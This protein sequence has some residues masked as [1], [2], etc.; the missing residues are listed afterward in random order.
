MLVA[1]GWT[2][3]GLPGDGSKKGTEPQ[4]GSMCV[5][6]GARTWN[7]HGVLWFFFFPPPGG[8]FGAT[9]GYQHG[10]PMGFEIACNNQTEPNGDRPRLGESGVR[11][12]G[13]LTRQG[14]RRES[15][16]RNAGKTE[17]R[18]I[19]RPKSQ[20]AGYANCRA[21]AQ[22]RPGGS[23][24]LRGLS[25]RR[26]LPPALRA[27]PLPEGGTRFARRPKRPN[28]DR[29]RLERQE[30]EGTR[31]EKATARPPGGPFWGRVSSRVGA[32]HVGESF[33]GRSQAAARTKPGPPGNSH[34]IA[35][36]A[37]R[38]QKSGGQDGGRP[39]HL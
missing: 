18:P 37:L 4:R 39:E 32:R 28:G 19:E 23:R 29:P 16:C 15:E 1:P 33:M 34:S 5:A 30:R 13:A 10:T 22:P 12:Q 3:S 8:P 26:V 6:S 17:S 7:P 24:A 21:D 35:E 27:T 38:I 25:P 9:G 14:A 20:T 36:N 2:R 31:E 11:S